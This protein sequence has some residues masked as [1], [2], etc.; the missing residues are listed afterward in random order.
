LGAP[1]ID[2]RQLEAMFLTHTSTSLPQSSPTNSSLGL[3]LLLVSANYPSLGSS[4]RT[5]PQI[6]NL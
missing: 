4:S 5:K 2:F 6:S 3:P 1:P